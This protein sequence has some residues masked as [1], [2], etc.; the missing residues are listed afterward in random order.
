MTCL[1]S[2]EN[3]T[4][5]LFIHIPKTAGTSVKTWLQNYYGKSNVKIYQ[6]APVTYKKL[7]TV[8][9]YKFTVIR[10]PYSRAVSWY[11]QA[12]S[13]ILLNE[14]QTRF[15]IHGLTLETWEKGFDYFLQNFFHLCGT[16]PGDD[17]PISPMQNQ[18]DYIFH[19]NI[20]CMDKII[21]FERLDE[22]F[23]FIQNLVGCDTDLEKHKVGPSDKIRN[24]RTVYTSES[25][26]LI[27]KF[28]EKDLNYFNY[29]FD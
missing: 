5:V 16:N 11:Q 23:K 22:D 14:A 24:W 21:Y 2:H 12:L 20:M 1:T 10:N 28:Y 4:N 29:C 8:E 27:E 6:H 17:I 25:K 19:N 7:Y 3:K 15:K 26:K 13:L 18:V 9:N